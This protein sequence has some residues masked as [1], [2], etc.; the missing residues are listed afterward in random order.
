MT[1]G[2]A[3]ADLIERQLVDIVP[4]TRFPVASWIFMFVFELFQHT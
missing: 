4:R 2:G 1:V 3:M